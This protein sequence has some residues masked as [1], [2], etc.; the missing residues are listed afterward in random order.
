ME[1]KQ[2]TV[3]KVNNVKEYNGRNGLI[4]YHNLTLDNG[5]KINIG[6][7][8]KLAQT[9]N[10]SYVLKEEPGQ[11]EFT[12][13][14]SAS[15]EEVEN[16]GLKPIYPRSSSNNEQ[17]NSS[18]NKDNLKVIKIGHAIAQAVIL[19]CSEIDL[20][21]LGLERGKTRIKGNA[22]IILQIGKELNEQ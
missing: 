1:V 12:P 13:A 6:K 20:T 7:K 2:S 8:S 19:E 18:G 3:Y 16:A 11:H 9:F 15:R 10:V 22:E 21:G 5:D 17:N 14:R 4:Y